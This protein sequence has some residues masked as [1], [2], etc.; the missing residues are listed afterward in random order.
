MAEF[1]WRSWHGAPTDL[2][3]ALIAKKAGAKT[4]EVTALAW[5]L[6]DYASQNDDRGSIDGFDVETFSMYSGI[7]EEEINRIIQAM[8]EKGII[9]S[10]SFAKWDKRQPKSESEMSRV[11]EYRR[12]KKEEALRDVTDCYEPLRIVTKNYTD[13]DTDTDK[14]LNTCG[15]QKTEPRQS[16]T[17]NPQKE[18]DL[19]DLG[20]KRKKPDESKLK[21]RPNIPKEKEKTV[22]APRQPDDPEFWKFAG[23]HQQSAIAFYK[24]AQVVPIG[25]EFGKWNKGFEELSEAGITPEEIPKIVAEM[26]RL[27]LTIN[28]PQSIL[29]VGRDMKAK[30]VL[31]KESAKQKYDGWNIL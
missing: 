10:G 31:A 17:P 7:E 8:E 12:K 5:A 18:P 26:H 9:E 6:M 14:E 21:S 15:S 23:K 24:S 30:Q 28:A 20:G 2:K 27:E 25:R 11:K 19:S 16:E 1:W 22:A 4:C 3:W 13:T 29:A